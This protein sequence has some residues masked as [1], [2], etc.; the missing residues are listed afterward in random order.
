MSTT[1]HPTGDAR[2]EQR[3][4]LPGKLVVALH[5]LVKACLLYSSENH[6]VTPLV[7]AAAAAVAELCAALDAPHARV[8]FADQLVFVN[9]RILRGTREA[10]TIGHELGALLAR[11]GVSELTFD[12]RVPGESLA[13]FARAAAD[14]VH[15]PAASRGL[16]EG[17]VAGVG[18]RWVDPAATDALPELERSAVA[19][20]VK[21]YA[22]AVVVMRRAFEALGRGDPQPAGRA[23]RV[24]QRL[25]ELAGEEPELVAA[26]ATGRFPDADPARVAVSTAVV[27]VAMA[28]RLTADPITL[29]S[30]AAAALLAE[31]GRLRLGD[32]PSSGDR[33][34]ASALVV[35]TSLGRLEPA[36]M[37]R[38]VIAH[39]ALLLDHGPAMGAAEPLALARV[40]SAARRFN[41]LRVPTPGAPG[42]GV[43]AAVEVMRVAASG[44]SA[45]LYLDLLVSGLGFFPLG[46]LVELTSGEIAVVTGAPASSVDFASPE[47]LLLADAS[48]VLVNRR[49]DLAKQ[50]P[51]QPRRAIRRA[52]SADRDKLAALHGRAR[53]GGA[54]GLGT[55]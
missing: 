10:A 3:R 51:G 22:T 45:R 50:A 54:P 20:V 38:T 1:L 19:R 48:G 44:P 28:R 26:L 41:D 34:A 49:V 11:G 5:H 8:L 14:A 6:A 29:A 35:L 47:V 39:E 13:A 9:G 55:G 46:T 21:A 4:I 17:Q 40:L 27:A 24:A 7:P 42:A 52:L 33:V 32:L 43:D 2:A 36:S 53:P 30:L 18:A 12:R 25:V 15:D 37:A 16:L 23:R 31:A